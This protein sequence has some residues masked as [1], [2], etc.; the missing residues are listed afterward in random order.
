MKICIKN[1]PTTAMNAFLF[2]RLPSTSQRNQQH[3]GT[4]HC[5]KFIAA[6]NFP[7]ENSRAAQDLF[8][9]EITLKI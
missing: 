5:C 3:Q 4:S 6:Y 9:L 7:L 2:F 8:F 1:D